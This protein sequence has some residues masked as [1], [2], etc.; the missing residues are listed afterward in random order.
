MGAQVVDS[1][2]TGCGENGAGKS[3]GFLLWFSN[4]ILNVLRKVCTTFEFNEILGCRVETALYY[5]KSDYASDLKD[6]VNRLQQELSFPGNKR[7][8]NEDG[9]C[10]FDKRPRIWTSLKLSNFI[11]QLINL[12]NDYKTIEKKGDGKSEEFHSK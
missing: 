6:F 5:R 8:Y 7:S 9:Q 2:G 10:V 12:R 4:D 3:A 11:D 1:R